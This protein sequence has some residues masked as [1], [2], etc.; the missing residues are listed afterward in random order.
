MQNTGENYRKLS[1]YADS[2]L[3]TFP[4]NFQPISATFPNCRFQIWQKRFWETKN[5]HPR[6]VF[7]RVL[8]AVLFVA[9]R[10]IELWFNINATLL[11]FV[12]FL[13]DII[14]FA[15]PLRIVLLLR[16]LPLS[17]L[18]ADYPKRNVSYEAP[19]YHSSIISSYF[20]AICSFDSFCPSGSS[21]CCT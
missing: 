12:C 3:T 2:S 16:A 4:N 9:L 19:I 5:K 15:I 10:F 1:N 8:Y 17:K 6:Y 21:F 20:F 7:P 13:T 18:I 14:R 11:F